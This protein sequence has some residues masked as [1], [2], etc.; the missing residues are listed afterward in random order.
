MLSE[1]LTLNVFGFLLVFARVGAAIMLYPGIAS[2]MVTVR[3]RVLIG[4]GVS[5]VIMPVVLPLLPAQPSSVLGLLV[6]L[7]SEIMIGVFLG[8]IAQIMMASLS[9]AGTAISL[10]IG[11]ASALVND[12]VMEQQSGIVANFLSNLAV[13][14]VFVSGLYALL[15][16]AI[17]ESY[18]V[19]MPGQY[20]PI[21]DLA[22]AVSRSVADSV[23]MGL[24]MAIP[25]IVVGLL[26]FSGLGLLSRLMPQLQIFFIA[27]PIQ[28]M[29]G[30]SILMIVLPAIMLSFLRFFEDH[31]SLFLTSG[32]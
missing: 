10:Q 32:M 31:L 8:A 2:G 20:V 9:F 17:A 16:Q 3:I 30:L 15:F 21:E 7:S 23:T 13:V 25:L 28:I 24:K 11:L 19:L 5:A 12:P 22:F 18:Y 1:I 29:L 6:L 4:L 26:F 14:L 27:M